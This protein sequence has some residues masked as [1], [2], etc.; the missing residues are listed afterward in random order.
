[1]TKVAP[2]C[3]KKYAEAFLISLQNCNPISKTKFKNGQ[4]VRIGSKIDL[5]H[6]GYRIQFTEEGFRIEAVQKLSPTPPPNVF[7]ER[8]QRPVDPRKVLR[9]RAVM[10]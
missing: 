4:Y 8:L 1:M 2:N 7:I 5:F 9:E 6:C 10:F 3:V